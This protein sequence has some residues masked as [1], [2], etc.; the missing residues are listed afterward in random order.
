MYHRK[1][2]Q[3]LRKKEWI[4]CYALHAMPSDRPIMGLA[5]SA[6]CLRLWLVHQVGSIRYHHLQLRGEAQLHLPLAMNGATRCHKVH[7]RE[8][9][10]TIHC[11]ARLWHRNRYQELYNN[12]TLRCYRRNTR[13]ELKCHSRR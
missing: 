3:A 6:K 8:E 1:V 11:G 9:C 10:T 7:S 13:V 4:I 5:H 2:I 12:S